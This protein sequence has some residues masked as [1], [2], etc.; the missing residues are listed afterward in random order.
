LGAAALG[1]LY[2]AVDEAVAMATVHAAVAHGWSYVDTAPLYGRG[3]SETRVGRAIRA[4]GHDVVVSTKVGRLVRSLAE[5]EEGDLFLG[6]PPGTADFDFST[7][8]IRASLRGSLDRLQRDRVDVALLHDPDDHLDAA[9]GDGIAALAAL[10]DEGLVTAIGVG[11][12]EVDAALRFVES[13]PIDVVLIAGRTTLL[14]RSAEA[15]LLPACADRGIAVVAGGVFNSGVLADP[16]AGRYAYGEVPAAVQ[17]R[18]DALVAACSRFD[19]PLAAAAIQHP[20]RHEAVSSIVVGCRSPGEIDR[21]ASLLDLVVPDE[22]WAELDA[23]ASEDQ[24]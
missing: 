17:T 6:A 2:A 21:N 11:T 1:G 20:L 24:R 23:I 12:N 18:L 3:L 16:A 14:D 22:L 19:V 13:A 9:L 15:A 7:A 5:R 4:G 8:G 10:R